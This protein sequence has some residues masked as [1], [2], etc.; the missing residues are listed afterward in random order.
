MLKSNTQSQEP[1]I[2]RNRSYNDFNKE[3]FLQD[4]QYG[5]KKNSKFSDFN[6]ELKE[7]LNHYAPIKQ[8]KPRGST[9]PY[10]NKTLRKELMKR[11]R[12]K[13]KASKLGKEEHKRSHNIQAKILYR[14]PQLLQDSQ[15]LPGDFVLSL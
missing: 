11:S 15:D 12:L 14:F 2:L 9:K 3:P 13:D 4:L 6:N 5:L 10:I 7:I 8:S 1:K